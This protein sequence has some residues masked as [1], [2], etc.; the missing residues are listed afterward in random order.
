MQE[1]GRNKN[2]SKLFFISAFIL[3]FLPLWMVLVFKYARIA[4]SENR[5]AMIAMI[6]LPVILIGWLLAHVTFRFGLNKYSK[7]V[8]EKFVF[9]K[10]EERKSISAEVLLS[11]VLP[12]L[13][14]NFQEAEGIMNF[15]VFFL[16]LLYLT[17]RY[18]SFQGNVFLEIIGYRFYECTIS[19][20]GRQV[21]V[22]SA[23][24][25]CGDEGQ[26]QE[27]VQLNNQVWMIY[28]KKGNA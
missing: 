23:M 26:T 7:K 28:E 15:C 9:S 6:G 10:I 17:C 1:N 19:T 3:S 22:I 8:P 21:K 24:P 13:A 2:M 4:P 18:N 5:H 12:L 25:L 11:Y 14:F 16:L 20:N 27:V